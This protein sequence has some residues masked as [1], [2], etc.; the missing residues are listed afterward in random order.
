MSKNNIKQAVAVL[1]RGG[2]IAYPTEAVF[3]LGCDPQQESSIKRLLEIKQRPA[4][5]GLILIASQISQLLPYI[6]I[7]AID[8]A[9]WR[10]VQASWPGPITWLLPARQQV[11]RLICGDHDSIAVRV[12]AHPV[13]KDLCNAFGAAITSTS[14]NLS[15]QPPT[16]SAN[17]VH[18]ELGS[19]V[20]YIV[21]GEVGPAQK[22]TEIRDALSG[23]II[24]PG[25]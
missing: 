5:K 18:A 14:A 16:R 10:E 15:D 21:D 19:L 8:A 13:V 3:G 4:A 22:P 1:Q 9:R 6:D 7:D 24:R 11:S 2:V 23:K 20:D 17:A 12:S 25:D